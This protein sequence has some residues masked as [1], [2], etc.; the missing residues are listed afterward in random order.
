[1]IRLSMLLV[2]VAGAALLL[3]VPASASG[4]LTLVYLS[5]GCCL[6]AAGFLA[7]G[8]SRPRRPRR[9]RHDDENANAQVPPPWVSHAVSERR[10]HDPRAPG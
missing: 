4:D 9:G 2:T 7:A 1:M 10:G 5:I 6:L 3:G 8:V